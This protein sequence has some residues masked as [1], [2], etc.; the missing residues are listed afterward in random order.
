VSRTE[1][2]APGGGRSSAQTTPRR[3]PD[4]DP[5]GRGDKRMVGKRGP[6]EDGYT[7]ALQRLND[8]AKAGLP[9]PQCPV[10]EAHTRW[11]PICTPNALGSHGI[12][13]R[14]WY[15]LPQG[16]CPARACKGMSGAPT[17]FS[18]RSSVAEHGMAY[19]ARALGSRS[20]KS[21]RGSHAPPGGTGEPCTGGS[22]TGGWM[23]GSCEVRVMRIAEA[24]Q[25]IVRAMLGKGHW[26]AD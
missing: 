5:K 7:G 4:L 10:V 19:G 6:V 2:I 1:C 14:L 15:A 24:G 12:A 17:S 18:R 16:R 22:G 3:P 9:D 20:A 13:F 8:R 26:R 21:T 23:T 11:E 25:V